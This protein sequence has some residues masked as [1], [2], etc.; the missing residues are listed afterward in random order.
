MREAGC[1]ARYHARAVL[2]T[3]CASDEGA[4]RA[5]M[6]AALSDAMANGSSTRDEEETDLLQTVVA[7]LNGHKGRACIEDPMIRVCIKMLAHLAEPGRPLANR[8]GIRTDSTRPSAKTM[9]IAPIVHS[10][11]KSG[12]EIEQAQL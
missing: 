10:L 5:A 7:R 9:C 1:I 2:N 6:S 11:G 3:W 12:K 8:V 4:Y